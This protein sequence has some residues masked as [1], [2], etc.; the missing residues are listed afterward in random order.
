MTNS[1][2][3]P[4]L[5]LSKSSL[6]GDPMYDRADARNRLVTCYINRYMG[7]EQECQWQL[8]SS[9]SRP[10]SAARRHSSRARLEVPSVASLGGGSTSARSSCSSF[11]GGSSRTRSSSYTG[12]HR[13][14]SKT[15]SSSRCSSTSSRCEAGDRDI[16]AAVVKTTFLVFCKP[17]RSDMDIDDFVK[18]CKSSGLVDHRFTAD[19][20]AEIFTK[21][22]PTEPMDLQHFVFALSF[23]ARSKEMLAGTVY[24]MVS[25]ALAF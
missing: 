6:R 19:D 20:V 1:G 18:I 9:R 7:E 3:L 23:V 10:S 25:R 14:S 12:S 4:P 15:G 8:A 5:S 13:S 22:S 16:Q 21:T 17:M 24:R 2:Q 11:A